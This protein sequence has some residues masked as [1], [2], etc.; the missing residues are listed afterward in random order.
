MK[1]KVIKII[2]NKDNNLYK[3]TIT[4]GTPIGEFTGN[5]I[6]NPKHDNTP[7]SPITGGIIAES[8][9]YIKYLEALMKDR[10]SQIKG[11]SRL[12][13]AMPHDKEGYIYVRRLSAAI[14]KEWLEFYEYRSGLLE[15]IENIYRSKKIVLNSLDKDKKEEQAKIRK[16]LQDELDK[17]KKQL[18]EDKND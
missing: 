15:R 9:A 14:F 12:Q 1:A 4:I 8:R 17:L 2:E 10:E 6:Y 7:Y 11:L 3:T 5:A 18:E 13:N 16:N